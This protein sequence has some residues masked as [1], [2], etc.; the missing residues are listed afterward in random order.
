MER[1]VFRWGGGWGGGGL[2]SSAFDDG[3]EGL[4]KILAKDYQGENPSAILPPE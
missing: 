2:A 3:F 4:R 1:K